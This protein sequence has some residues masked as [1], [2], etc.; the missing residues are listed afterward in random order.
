[1]KCLA[2]DN[3]LFV[4]VELKWRNGIWVIS[5]QLVVQV[6]LLLQ[7]SKLIVCIMKFMMKLLSTN[8]FL[9][10]LC[11]LLISFSSI[12]L[13]CT[14]TIFDEILGS[15]TFDSLKHMTANFGVVQVQPSLASNF[16]W[17]SLWMSEYSSDKDS[18]QAICSSKLCLNY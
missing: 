1:M 17:L 18:L 8:G 7:H 16:K 4:C 11:S 2:E 9:L 10:K 6:V 5:Q 15:S 14:K 12:C 13:I 3:A